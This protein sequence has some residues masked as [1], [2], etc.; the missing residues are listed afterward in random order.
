[1]W[2]ELLIL[3]VQQEQNNVPGLCCYYT[4]NKVQKVFQAVMVIK[5]SYKV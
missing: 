3:G 2:P 1:M 5:Q 4:V